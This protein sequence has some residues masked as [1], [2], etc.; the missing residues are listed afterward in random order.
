MTVVHHADPETFLAAARGVI[1]R[2]EAEGMMLESRVRALLARERPGAERLYLATIAGSASGAAFQLDAA[3]LSLGAS[4]GGAAPAFAD[5]LVAEHPGLHGVYGLPFRLRHHVLAAVND[6]PLPRGTA[7]VA[8]PDDLDW[9][10]ERARAFVAEVGV[11]ETPGDVVL[12]H[13]RG[14]ARGHYWIWDD[15]GAVAYAGWSPANATSARVAP[16]YTDPRHRG[17][18]YATALVAAMSRALLDAGHARLSLTTDLA[19]PVSNAIY[20]RI[21]YRPTSEAMHVDFTG[22]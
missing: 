18:G 10:A 15:G 14:I 13:R 19:N 11:P 8:G 20:A 9:L 1:A 21:G 2:D 7:R 5:D 3:P 17:R 12:R 6:V 22:A 16:V 4:D